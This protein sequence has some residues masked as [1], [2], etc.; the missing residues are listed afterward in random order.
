[1]GELVLFFHSHSWVRSQKAI[2]KLKRCLAGFLLV[3][4]CAPQHPTPFSPLYAASIS[5]P[6]RNLLLR[7]RN[8]VGS[9]VTESE[10][11]VQNS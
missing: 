8:S 5:R 3:Q 9:A 11:G 1:V 7:P 10:T 6:H 4:P 2:W